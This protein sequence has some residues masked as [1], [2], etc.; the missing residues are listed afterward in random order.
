MSEFK[1][2]CFQSE[3]E[4]LAHVIA[5]K[6]ES[7]DRL[8]T[9]ADC[10]FVHNNPHAAEVFQT[11]AE[12]I[13]Q[14]IQQLELNATGMQLPNIPPWEYQWHCS[15]DPEALCMDQAHY[16]MS[17]RQ[18]LELAL[19]NEQRSLNFFKKV[20]DDVDHSG[21]TELA[22]QQIEMEQEFAEFIQQQLALVGDDDFI[23]EDLDPPNMPE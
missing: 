2:I 10:L 11:L 8:Q 17:I 5:L 1:D 22:R 3:A 15:D 19:F 13:A 4:F 23:C 7:E 18:A 9:M 20:F 12:F 14:T 16:M 21:I 6:C